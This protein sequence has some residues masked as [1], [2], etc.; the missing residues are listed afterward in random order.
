MNSL[1]RFIF[2]SLIAASSITTLMGFWFQAWYGLMG[3]VGFMT[4]AVAG[5]PFFFPN[6]QV[7]WEKKEIKTS[8]QN[9]AA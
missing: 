9:R 8:S 3:L 5:I 7:K 4:F 2:V 6:D 1:F